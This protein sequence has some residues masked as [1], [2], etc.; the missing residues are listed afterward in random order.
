MQADRLG[1]H[2]EREGSRS[3]FAVV[4]YRDSKFIA[5]RLIRRKLAVR[6][7][8]C[9]LGIRI[10]QRYRYM[11]VGQNIPVRIH[12]MDHRQDELLAD[13]AE[14]ILRFDLHR[15]RI[16]AV[17]L[18]FAY[19]ECR[20]IAADAPDREQVAVPVG[21]YGTVEHR[22]R[23]HERFPFAARNGLRIARCQRNAD[24]ARARGI[25]LERHAVVAFENGR[26]HGRYGKCRAC[27]RIDR[28]TARD[29]ADLFRHTGDAGGCNMLIRNVA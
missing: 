24:L 2:V 1:R 4:R 29:A 5:A 11:I 10:L 15:G 6:R 12:G 25:H 20:D 18:N 3:G 7:R 26:I 14:G 28:E 8:K 17:C 27:L 22:R 19:I 9:L 23:H 13:N 16:F 21:S